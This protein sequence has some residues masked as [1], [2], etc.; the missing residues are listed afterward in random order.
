M[1]KS[2][3][4][5]PCLALGLA[6]VACG[7]DE[8]SAESTE[9]P[10]VGA[11]PSTPEAETATADEAEEG[12]EASDENVFRTTVMGME[13]TRP[14]VR[15]DLDDAGLEGLTMVVPEGAELSTTRWGSHTIVEA[16][17]NYS[18]SVSE[19]DFDAGSTL[20]TYQTLDPDGSVV[21]Q[22]EDQ[23]IY[24]RSGGGSLLFTVGDTSYTCGTAATAFPFTRDQ[25][26]QMIESCRTLAAAE[27]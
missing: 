22:T 6:C 4:L 25:V 20:E 13:M 2:I 7:G 11:T 10:S 17:V 16:G 8:E 21:E 23:L 3:A 9:T 1:K 5:V 18:V 19:G 15:Q 12:A 26:D 24:Q 14:L 27:G